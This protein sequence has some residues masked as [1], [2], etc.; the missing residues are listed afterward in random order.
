MNILF[1]YP[2]LLHS[3]AAHGSGNRMLRLIQALSQNGHNI[4]CL[5]L[6]EIDPGP[7]QDGIQKLHELC[8]EFTV[9]PRPRLTLIRKIKSFISPRMP[10]HAKNLMH[11]KAQAY[12]RDLTSSGKID[13]VILVFTATGSYLNSIDRSKCTVLLDADDL[14][15]RRYQIALKVETNIAKWFHAWITWFREKAYEKQLFLSVDHIITITPQEKQYIHEMAPTAQITVIPPM[16]DTTS[17]APFC[18]EEDA[19]VF[20]GSFSHP[21]NVKGIRWFCKEVFPQV[22]QSNKKAHLYIVGWEAKKYVGDLESPGINI[23]DS[24]ENVLPWLA[25]ASIIISPILSGGGARIKNIEALAMGRPLVT[26]SLGAEGLAEEPNRSFITADSASSFA[27]AVILLLKD[28]EYRLRLG[29]AGRS[30]I[31]NRHNTQMVIAQ[32]EKLLNAIFTSS[33]R[34]FRIEN[35]S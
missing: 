19:I 29:L 2:F 30:L 26:T 14:E 1:I 27:E 18:P 4:Y 32:F 12:I 13:F 9:I 5:S 25:R 7:Y 21:P 11:P 24:P 23:I 31:E 10:P 22:I 6:A 3:L 15:T 33:P 16:I 34:Y 28:P 8:K 35:K 17:S 20:C